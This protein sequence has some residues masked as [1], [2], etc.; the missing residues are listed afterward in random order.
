MGAIAVPASQQ[1]M[2]AGFIL[3]T[4]EV[5]VLVSRFRFLFVLAALLC[6]DLFQSMFTKIMFATAVLCGSVPMLS[7]VAADFVKADHANDIALL[8]K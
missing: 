3:L 8:V 5:V 7:S 6:L 4:M 1:H 2:T